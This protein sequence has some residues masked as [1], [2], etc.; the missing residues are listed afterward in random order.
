M[1]EVYDNILQHE[2]VF[3][4]KMAGENPTIPV[5]TGH[6][7]SQKTFNCSCKIIIITK[8]DRVP[9]KKFNQ[10][11]FSKFFLLEQIVIYYSGTLNNSCELQCLKCMIN[12][13]SFLFNKKLLSDIL[14]E[15]LLAFF[16]QDISVE[17]FGEELALKLKK[18]VDE[19]LR[20]EK[21]RPEMHFV[22]NILR[23]KITTRT[24]TVELY[25]VGTGTGTTGIDERT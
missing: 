25:C 9:V 22:L 20:P 2:T 15:S 14:R 4:K 16:F 19:C 18:I 3:N 1:Q 7:K 11:G 8:V 12:F 17:E 6:E 5:T 21:S 13:H 23:G 10:N 24:N